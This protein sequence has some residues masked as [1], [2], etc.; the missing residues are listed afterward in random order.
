MVL[1]PVTDRPPLPVIWPLRVTAPLV[2]PAVPLP[3]A[4]IPPPAFKLMLRFTVSAPEPWAFNSVPLLVESPRVKA[5]EVAPI[6]LS[7]PLTARVLP[8]ETVVP[9]V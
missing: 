9:P 7:F 4:M 6:A 8:P 3:E 1:G 2:W 5:P